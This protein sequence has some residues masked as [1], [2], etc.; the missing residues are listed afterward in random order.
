M[1]LS[2]EVQAG[3]WAAKGFDAKSYR[4]KQFF[5]TLNFNKMKVNKMSLANIQG[6]LSRAEMKNIFGGLSQHSYCTVTNN[7]DSGGGTSS[8]YCNGSQ[9]DCQNTADALCANNDCCD[10]LDCEPILA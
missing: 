7:S 6:M 2:C 10:D 5:I 1:E 8:Y 9:D 4:H 3:S